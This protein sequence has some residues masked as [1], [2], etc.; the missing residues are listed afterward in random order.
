MHDIASARLVVWLTDVYLR[1]THADGSTDDIRRRAGDVDRARTCSARV[2]V[3]ARCSE[4]K[5]RSCQ[6]L[7][8]RNVVAVQK[9]AT[10]TIVGLAA[11]DVRAS[12]APLK[13]S[14]ISSRRRQGYEPTRDAAMAAFAKSWRRE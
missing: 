11:C 13:L 1:D 9:R 5:H 6:L 14:H 8:P 12:P 7:K 4:R 3:T 10:P 2:S